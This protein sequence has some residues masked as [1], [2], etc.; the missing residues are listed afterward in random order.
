LFRKNNW[1]TKLSIRNKN[2]IHFNK[3]INLF[4]QNVDINYNSFIFEINPKGAVSVK[5]L[6][7]PLD[8]FPKLIGGGPSKHGQDRLLM[9]R[10][11]RPIHHRRGPVLY[12]IG[13]VFLKLKRSMFLVSAGRTSVGV[14]EAH[15]MKPPLLPVLPV[16]VLVLAF[17][18]PYDGPRRLLLFNLS[19]FCIAPSF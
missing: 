7:T 12:P 15:I 13:K 8:T 6:V 1:K 14:V 16:L 3:K 9:T 17:A 2:I 19:H 18:E 10:N 4:Y 5:N 11:I